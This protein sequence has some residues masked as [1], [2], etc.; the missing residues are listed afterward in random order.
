MLWLSFFSSSPAAG[1]A[2]GWFLRAGRGAADLARAQAELV[3]RTTIATASTICTAMPSSMRATSAGRRRNRVQRENAA[4]SARPA[5]ESL[6]E[7]QTK[8]TAIERN[9]RAV[10]HS[11]AAVAGP[12]S[13][14][15]LCGRRPSRSP[16]L[17]VPPPRAASGV[18]PGAA[19]SSKPRTH[20]AHR[21]RSAGDDLLR[22]WSGAPRH[23]GDPPASASIAVDAKVPRRLRGLR[24][25]R[26]RRA[27]AALPHLMQKHV[28]VVR[29]H[30][31]ALAKKAYWA[32]LSK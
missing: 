29:A 13:P 14:M 9:A 12:R 19:A 31:D 16:G 2:M 1:V 10:R 26:R 18:R 24:S 27:G 22:P 28:K 6:Q 17:C 21:L 8:V 25:S 23:A 3:Y 4:D 15:K 5:R 30:I 32:G 7:M 20:P 11:R